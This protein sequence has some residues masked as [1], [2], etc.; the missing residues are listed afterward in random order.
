MSAILVGVIIAFVYGPAITPLGI[1]LAAILIGAQIGIALFLKKQSSRDS[2]MAHRPSRLVIEAIEHHETVQCL[3]QEQRFHDL[4]EDHMNE[5]QRHGIVRVLI[6]ACATSLQAC[7]AF[8]NFA[9]L[10]RLGVTLVGSNRYHPF[11]VFQVVESLNCASISLLTFKIY[12]PEYVRARFS[13]G[14]IF[15]ML[16]QRPKI[17]SYTEAGHRYSFDGMDS[18]EINVRY[19]RSQMALVESKP[20][21]FSYTVKENITYGLPILSHQQIEEAALLAGAH[22][23]IQ[24]LPKVSAIQKRVFRMTSFCCVE[25]IA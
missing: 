20:V 22:D 12:A 4:F 16:R 24:L 19:L 25:D 5:I 3:V 1:L 10:Y 15:N 23:F 13:A 9:C 11:S 6:E 14:L 2:A 17:D 18:R 21:L 7:F 8:I